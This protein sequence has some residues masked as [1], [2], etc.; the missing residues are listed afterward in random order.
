MAC[1]GVSDSQAFRHHK[2][3]NVFDT[4]GSAD[5]TANVDFAYLREAM[6]GKGECT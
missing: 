3:V 2:I 6:Q 1:R 4:P 5:L